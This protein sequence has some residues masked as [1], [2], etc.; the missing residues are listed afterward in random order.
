MYTLGFPNKEVE[1]GFMDYLLPHYTSV[2]EVESPFQIQCFVDDVENGR[3]E[4]FIKRLRSFFA[5]TPGVYPEHSRRELIKDLENHYQNVLFIIYRLMGFYTKAE[6]HTSEGRID[7]VIQT[8]DYCYVMEF[9]L[10]GTAEEAMAQIKD[11]NYTLP[12]EMNGQKIIRIGMNFSSETRNI[13]GVVI[14]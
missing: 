2:D 7:M 10:D 8:A 9:K 6:Y 11:T 13:D 12:F 5:D 3:T 1:E 14:E 4:Q